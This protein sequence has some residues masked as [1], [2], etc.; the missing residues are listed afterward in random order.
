MVKFV[1]EHEHFLV[2]YKPHGMPTV[3]LAKQALTGTTLL[4]AVASKYPEVMQACSDHP[5][6]GL[7]LHRLDT[8]TAGLVLCARSKQAFLALQE[9]QQQGLF[10]K[11]YIAGCRPG[12]APEGF[13]EYP[14]PEVSTGAVIMIESRFRA[15][16]PKSKAVRPVVGSSS[17]I[18]QGKASDTLYST[19]LRL[20]RRMKDVLLFRCTLAKGFRHQ[21]RCH[22][23]WSGYPL[24]GDPMYGGSDADRLFLTASG[25]KFPLFTSKQIFRIRLEVLEESFPAEL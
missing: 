9:Y 15:Y 5:W 1:Y 4:E 22:L 10:I 14:G 6:E 2:V 8:D 17:P 11:T 25:L 18:A 13:P 24:I 3:P 19:T 16:G 12:Y 20:E 7:V 23:A 21:V